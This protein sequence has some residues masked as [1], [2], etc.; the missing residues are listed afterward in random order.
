M[1]ESLGEALPKE[2]ARV[3]KLILQYRDPMLCGAGNFAA[4][5]MEKALKEAD[6]AVISGDVVRMI[7]AYEDLKGYNE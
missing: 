3:R 7:Q 2:Q 4:M 1:N 6:E 5:M